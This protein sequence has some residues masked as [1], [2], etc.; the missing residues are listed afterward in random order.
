MP[1]DDLLLKFDIRAVPVLE[2]NADTARHDIASAVHPSRSLRCPTHTNLSIS[3]RFG[4]DR[5]VFEALQIAWRFF[6]V[7][8][9]KPVCAQRRIAIFPAS[10]LIA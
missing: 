5:A 3:L 9:A 1:A 2:R 10:W 4:F 8:E 7:A 6:A